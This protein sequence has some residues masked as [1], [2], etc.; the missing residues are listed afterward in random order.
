[1]RASM[2][3]RVMTPAARGMPR[4]CGDGCEVSGVDARQEI[5]VLT[6][7]T[8]I[9]VAPYWSWMAFS[10]CQMTL[11]KNSAYGAYS[12]ICRIELMMTRIAQ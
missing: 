9:A 1:M 4:Y 5:D 6:M 8:A 7:S 3:K 2:P 11:M 12:T 10:A